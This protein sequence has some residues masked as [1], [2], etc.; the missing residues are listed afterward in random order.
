MRSSRTQSKDDFVE[1]IVEPNDTGILCPDNRGTIWI[2][3]KS[4][5]TDNGTPIH[6]SK[7]E[8]A[9]K[10]TNTA[11]TQ[12]TVIYKIGQSPHEKTYKDF[13]FEGLE[14]GLGIYQ[15][16]SER[17]LD[18]KN[19]SN[20]AVVQL[21]EKE[22]KKIKE[23]SASP[24]KLGD[25]YTVQ[26]FEIATQ[27]PAVE[28][29]RRY[30]LTVTDDNSPG[31]TITVPVT[32]AGLPFQDALLSAETIARASAILDQ[33]KKLLPNPPNEP[34][35]EH[36]PLI[37]SQA[38]YGRNATLMTY[39]DVCLRIA[40]GTVKNEDDIGK[41]VCK[42]VEDQREIRPGF[43]HSLPQ[44]E[45]LVIALEKKL[46]ER[47]GQPSQYARAQ[48]SAIRPLLAAVTPTVKPTPVIRT[49]L[50]NIDAMPVDGIAVGSNMTFDNQHFTDALATARTHAQSGGTASFTPVRELISR[51]LNKFPQGSQTPKYV[52]VT[53]LPPQ[54]PRS[55]RPH[56]PEQVVKY[57]GKTLA[58]AVTSGLKSVGFSANLLAPTQSRKQGQL[59]IPFEQMTALAVAAVVRQERAPGTPISVDFQCTDVGQQAI[60]NDVI[61]QK[62]KFDEHQYYQA[63]L[64][65]PNNMPTPIPATAL[66]DFGNSDKRASFAPIALKKR[67]D[68]TLQF[69]LATALPTHIPSS[70][71]PFE[72]WNEVPTTQAKWEEGDV[73]L[74]GEPPSDGID[75]AGVMIRENDGRVWVVAPT[76]GFAGMKNTFPKGQTVDDDDPLVKWSPQA[77]ARKEAYEESGLQVKLTAFLCDYQGEK[78]KT[79]YYLA[80][81]IGGTPAD[82]GWESQ[83]VHLVPMN[84][85]RGMMTR[86]NNKREN[87][88]LNLSRFN[89]S[90]DATGAFSRLEEL[91]RSPGY[92][93][94]GPLF[95]DMAQEASEAMRYIG[96]QR[97]DRGIDLV[98]ENQVL[99]RIDSRQPQKSTAL[100]IPGATG[101]APRYLHA[102]R[103]E[104]GVS[105]NYIAA[106]YPLGNSMPGRENRDDF[107]RATT[108]SKLLIPDVPIK[109][110][111]LIVDLTEPGEKKYDDS[112][113]PVGEKPLELPTYEL[114]SIPLQGANPH[115][116]ESMIQIKPHKG[117]GTKEVQRMH[118][119]AWPDK[120]AIEVDALIDLANQIV[121]NSKDKDTVL[122]HC[123]HG[124]GRTGTLIT[125]LAASE[126][127]ETAIAAATRSN[128]DTKL[129]VSDFLAIVRDVLIKGRQA[130]GEQ[131]VATVQFPLIIKALLQQHFDSEIV[132]GMLSPKAIRASVA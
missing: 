27:E 80:E 120:K 10:V 122:I 109:E 41:Q 52:L 68:D 101:S 70:P 15:F 28:G 84:E 108:D 16:V 43:V 35:H 30:L 63:L 37:L 65:L 39:R 6:A 46:R 53:G 107:W 110:V 131:F 59:G 126:K 73:V 50:A 29:C 132:D 71:V 54:H 89:L 74:A 114:R 14:S 121:L 100:R 45:Q 64:R 85:L 111:S 40:D 1:N 9:H 42:F 12:K 18:N 69:D 17:T 75:A 21:L 19:R 116:N 32:Q 5:T 79:R 115:I 99:S 112:Y 76:G 7:F 98:P 23:N 86:P 20:T 93:V 67:Q 91:L 8:I 62:K 38:G 48:S 83:A 90:Y 24:L 11:E 56:L 127:I 124:V 61:A 102:N 105:R 47:G 118:F 103:I 82:V 31:K 36:D 4:S 55:T 96:G 87:Q 94:D 44:V 49:S 123:S 72:S 95:E 81:R 33:H 26:S 113:A 77:T 128:P 66:T 125:F 57:V 25:R 119:T 2:K 78:Q 92:D 13:L 58:A 22:L 51:P 97:K 117:G 60:V 106:Q 130:R 104:L 3:T 34:I 88:V 129:S